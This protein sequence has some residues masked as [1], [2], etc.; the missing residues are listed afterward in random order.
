MNKK[1]II[2]ISPPPITTDWEPKKVLSGSPGVRMGLLSIGSV[3]SQHSY[4]VKILDGILGK[5]DLASELHQIRPQET[6]FVGI[7]SMTAQLPSAVKAATIIREKHPSLPIIWGGVHATLFPEETCSDSLADIV[8]IGEGEYT[9]LELAEAL[10]GIRDLHSIKGIVYKNGD[11]KTIFTGNRSHHDLNALPFPKYELFHLDDY[12]YRAIIDREDIKNRKFGKMLSIHSGM[13]CP[14]QCTFCINTTVYR[15]GKYYTRSPYRGKSAVRLL[16]EI[17]VL[18]KKYNVDFIDFIDENFLVDKSRFFQFLDGI[19]ERQLTFTW[20]AGSRAN[21][22]NP[23]YLTHD[24]IARA[25]ALGCVMM[26]IGA[27]SGSQRILDFLKK[28]ITVEQIEYAASA[29]NKH[30]IVS[31]FSFMIGLP[32]ETPD[33]M[34]KTIRFV[35]K[36]RTIGPY[37]GTQSPQLYRPIPGGEL[38]DECVKLGFAAPKG[39]REWTSEKLQISGYLHLDKL[40]WI[41][42][43]NKTVVI[44]RYVT[45]ILSTMKFRWWL[46][47]KTGSFFLKNFLLH[48]VNMIFLLRERMD[49]WK[50]PVEYTCFE[51]LQR[52]KK[53]Y[54]RVR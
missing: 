36:L 38:Y 14:Y 4:S 30:R 54:H 23:G 15:D 44:I 3:L 13:G 33:D 51:R 18:L 35:K 22:F 50:F 43:D 2:L 34:L 7:S 27:E 25:S 29:L 37:V 40:P 8:V 46:I 41:N 10:S 45:G 32:Y 39:I 20:F 49:F 9:C 1:T 28:G 24:V 31:E 48:V 26:G 12:L 47:D 21:Y 16:D 19:E 11:G 6:L 5:V 52:F 17:E 42:R 53:Y